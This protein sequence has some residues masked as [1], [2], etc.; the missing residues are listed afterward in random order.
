M[1]PSVCVNMCFST[2][3]CECA[4]PSLLSVF[5]NLEMKPSAQLS[6]DSE[7]PRLFISPPFSAPAVMGKLLC[8]S[9]LVGIGGVDKHCRDN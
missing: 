4:F 2:S 7:L 9:A 3:A 8:L 6:G 5:L 1:S